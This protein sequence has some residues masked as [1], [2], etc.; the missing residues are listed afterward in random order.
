MLNGEE[1]D[2]SFCWLTLNAHDN[3]CPELG[4]SKA[5][6]VELHLALPHGFQGSKHCNFDYLLFPGASSGSWI[7]N[8]VAGI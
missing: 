8:R 7:G 4:Q 6:S 1:R 5:K 3:K 2:R